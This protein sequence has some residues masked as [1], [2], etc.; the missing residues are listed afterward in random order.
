[1]INLDGT[2]V[3]VIDDERFI[4]ATIRTVLRM[5]GRVTVTEA[6]DGDSG[7]LE[8]ER[9]KPDVVLCDIS[10][11]RMAGPRFV[12]LLRKHPEAGMRDT[13]VIILTGHAEEAMVIGARRLKI[14]GYLIKPISPKQ[15]G[16]QMRRVLSARR[17]SPRTC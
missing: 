3:L 13:P 2:K 15:L 7:L 8:I 10:M 4:R 17:V 14:D 16:D 12:E 9:S 6:D 1:M 11:P 5:V